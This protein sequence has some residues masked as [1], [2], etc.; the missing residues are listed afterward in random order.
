MTCREARLIVP[1]QDDIHANA[2]VIRETRSALIREFGGFTSFRVAGGWA[3]VTGREYFEGGTAFDIAVSLDNT[4]VTESTLKALARKIAN[5]AH[6][7]AVYLRL[8]SGAV[9]FITSGDLH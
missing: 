3:D 5:D 1:D 2:R 6:Q 4:G 8:P 7:Q 9:E